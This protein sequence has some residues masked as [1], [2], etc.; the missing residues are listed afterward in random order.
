MNKRK[1][2]LNQRCSSYSIPGGGGA[3]TINTCNNVR[4]LTPA[5]SAQTTQMWEI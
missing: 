2:R 3:Y 1:L 5:P 4:P